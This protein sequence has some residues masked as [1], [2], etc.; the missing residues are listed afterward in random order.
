MNAIK[1]AP[2]QCEDEDIKGK[3]K[4]SAVVNQEKDINEGWKKNCRY[5]ENNVWARG[6]MEFLF[7]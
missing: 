2:K 7:E 3:M 1:D 6:D 4:I 5:I